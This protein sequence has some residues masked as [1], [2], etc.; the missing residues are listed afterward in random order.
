[1]PQWFTDLWPLLSTFLGA[2]IVW[3]VLKTKVDI[4]VKD[5]DA[6]CSRV[7]ENENKVDALQV[8]VVERLA[9]LETLVKDNGSSRVSRDE[10]QLIERLTRIESSLN[11]TR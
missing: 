9:R 7:T 4:L 6:T 8:Q 3:G 2:G 11:A 5:L 10:A 1:M